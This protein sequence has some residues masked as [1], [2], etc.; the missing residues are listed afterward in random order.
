MRL[1]ACFRDEVLFSAGQPRQ[2]IQNWA[3]FTLKR[4]L[5]QVNANTHLATQGAGYMRPHFLPTAEAGVLLDTFHAWSKKFYSKL[6]FAKQSRNEQNKTF[7]IS[8]HH[9]CDKEWNVK[10]ND[11]TDHL[12]Q[13]NFG[14]IHHDK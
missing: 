11:S 5:G 3:L 10:R 1:S 9:Q 4:G 7:P 8:H 2:P 13:G 14:Y 12:P 6:N